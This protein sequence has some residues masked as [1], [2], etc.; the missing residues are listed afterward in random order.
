M[1]KGI[2]WTILEKRKRKEP[3]SA[4]V[5]RKWNARVD[6]LSRELFLKCRKVS[7]YLGEGR[8]EYWLPEVQSVTHITVMPLIGTVQPPPPMHCLKTKTKRLL[9]KTHWHKRKAWKL[10]AVPDKQEI[11]FYLVVAQA[12]ARTASNKQYI[13]H[14]GRLGFSSNK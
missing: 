2:K 6:V 5:P 13:A 3:N 8:M 10:H 4:K 11:E 1:E 12:R 7:S 14:Y 9:F